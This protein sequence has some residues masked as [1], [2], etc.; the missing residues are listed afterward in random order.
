MIKCHSLSETRFREN[1]AEYWLVPP[2]SVP[3]EMLK[4]KLYGVPPPEPNKSIK[5]Q[6]VI[7]KKYKEIFSSNI[8]F[9]KTNG[10]LNQLAYKVN[11]RILNPPQYIKEGLSVKVLFLEEKVSLF[12]YVLKKVNYFGFKYF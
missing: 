12:N 8:V 7:D 10:K 3:P 6:G 5:Y 9:Q 1:H 4:A 2:E 11:I